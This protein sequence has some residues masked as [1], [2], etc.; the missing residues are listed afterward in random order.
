YVVL[1]RRFQAIMRSE[2]RFQLAVKG[3]NDGIWEWE[4]QQDRVYHSS[5]FKELLGY[6]DTDEFAPKT[7][8]F[9]E[10]IHPDDAR[11]TEL[12]L[13]RHLLHR[14][15]YDVQ[16]RLRTRAGEY[17]WFCARAQAL[18]DEHGNAFRMA[19]S[20]SDIHDRK[21]AE[22][23]LEK[24]RYA[25]LHAE[26]EFAQRLLLAQEQERQRLANELHDGVGQNLSLI[27]NRAL[28][29]MQQT[30]LPP[31][32]TRHAASLEQLATEVISEVRAV[33]QNL[34]PLH[35]DELGLTNV[36][37]SLLNK[38][39]EAGGLRI[40]KRLENVDDAVKGEAATHVFR[41]VQE[42][43]NNIIK[44]AH[45]K[46]CRITLER[47]IHCVRLIIVDDGIGFDTRISHGRGLGLASLSERCRMM[48]ATLKLSSVTGSG[49]SIYIEYAVSENVMH[50]DEIAGAQL[51]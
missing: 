50:A 13:Q 43:I 40:E 30:D 2:Q 23:E 42:A 6:S 22:S 3:T 8:S 39:S 18:W 29:M 7:S 34:R 24:I 25:E 9:W 16:F 35:I 38:V 49:T 15:P 45:A 19:G 32:I 12:A 17:R 14:D 26:Q 27:K 10:R 28:L 36:I 21:Q 4:I 33:A 20:I 1:Q 11:P 37:D 41:I 31:V 46:S 51:T 48:S 47:D 44:H 5:R